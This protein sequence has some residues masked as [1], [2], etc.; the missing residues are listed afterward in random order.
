MSEGTIS[1]RVEQQDTALRYRYD[2]DGLRAL[3]IALVV[4]Y[5]VWFGRV[6]GGVDVF[7]MISAFFMTESLTRRAV[8]GGKPRLARYWANRF[9]RLVPP[10]AV[11]ILGILV[12]AYLVYP[13]V[14]WPRIWRE[15][16]ASLLYFENWTLANASV[17]YYNVDGNFQSPL[18]H[19]WSLSIQGQVFLLFPLAIALCGWALRHHR[20][21]I[22]PVLGVVFGAAFIASLSWSIIETQANQSFA[23]FDTRTRIWEFAAGALVALLLPFLRVPGWLAAFLG[24]AGVIGIVTCGMVLDVQGGFPGYL[25]LWPV[26]CTAAVLI[27]GTNQVASGPYRFLTSAPLRFVGKDAYALY[28]VHWPVLIT[29]RVTHENAAPNALEGMG[30]IAISVV[31][32]RLLRWFVDSPIRRLPREGLQTSR[33]LVVIVASMAL[34]MTPLGLWQKAEQDRL[35]A[36]MAQYEKDAASLT[37]SSYPGAAS[38]YAAVPVPERMP[39]VPVSSKLQEE[40]V[41]LDEACQGTAEPTAEIVRVRCTQREGADQADR[42]VLVV[43]DSRAQQLTAPLDAIAEK[44]GLGLIRSIY[45]ACPVGLSEEPLG[46][47]WMDSDDCQAWREAVLDYALELEPDAVYLVATTARFDQPERLQDGIE[48]FI[49]PLLNAGIEVVALR[50]NPRFADQPGDESPFECAATATNPAVDCGVPLV[51]LLAEGE[52]PLEDLDPR[53]LRV[54]FTPW[55]CPEGVCQAAIGNIAVY[56]DAAHVTKTYG[57]TLAPVLEQQLIAGGFLEEYSGLVPL[58]AVLSDE[59]R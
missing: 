13:Q 16:W 53:V 58:D 21:R 47:E 48:D 41:R 23:Y 5:H 37:D 45:L 40:W 14:E 33:G 17:D 20:N 28:L 34:V 26:L 46:L 2:I 27:G 8:R 43:G 12:A 44:Q 15:S 36:I 31:L 25:A 10:A 39:L 42:I 49:D 11:T 30:I 51:E 55:L 54:D 3:A 4:I 18:Q 29:W 59:Q 24:W 7:L 56:F 38:I 35:D 32:A 57:L 19:F 6:S 50:S 1:Q 52:S 22:R 9:R